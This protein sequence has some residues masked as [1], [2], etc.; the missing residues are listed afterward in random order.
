MG[1]RKP[2]DA[3][4]KGLLEV[5]Q[6]YTPTHM[7]TRESLIRHGWIRKTETVKD[8]VTYYGY[9]LTTEGR[10]IAEENV[11]RGLEARRRRELRRAR[12]RDGEFGEFR[13]VMVVV[14]GFC[15]DKYLDFE[16]GSRQVAETLTHARHSDWEY[17]ELHG[18]TCPACIARTERGQS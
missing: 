3:Q 18:W 1:S 13:S 17:T 2:S 14:C 15:H 4:I 11:Q 8:G 5:H 7:K 10:A 12:L 6:G 9:A 16:T